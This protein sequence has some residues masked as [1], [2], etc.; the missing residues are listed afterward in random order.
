MREEEA[1][2]TDLIFLDAAYLRELDHRLDE[3]LTELIEPNIEGKI[4]QPKQYHG[5]LY[6]ALREAIDQHGFELDGRIA[7]LKQLID[8]AN[9][10]MKARRSNYL[11][12]FGDDTYRDWYLC[13]LAAQKWGCSPE[14]TFRFRETA[15]QEAVLLTENRYH[16]RG[17]SVVADSIIGRWMGIEALDKF[18]PP[19][20]RTVYEWRK[21]PLY[22]ELAQHLCEQIADN[23]G[24][25][26]PVYKPQGLVPIF[27]IIFR[28]YDADNPGPT[29]CING[30][31]IKL[32]NHR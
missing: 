28:A 13:Q 16:G 6:Y 14:Q 22:N 7:Q 1:D 20:R 27:E 25:K 9:N 15:E 32:Q 24:Y 10:P 30:R 23:N 31:E 21:K 19:P 18:D 4:Q 5:A 29:L 26:E 12:P 8:K 2:P 11:N 3:A 17:A